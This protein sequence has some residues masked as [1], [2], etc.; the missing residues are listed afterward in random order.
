[1]RIGRDEL[2]VEHASPEVREVLAIS[3]EMRRQSCR[4]F[5]TWFAADRKVAPRVGFAPLDPSGIVKGWAVATA[6]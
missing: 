2:R 5:N 6:G 3:E 1:M 4:A